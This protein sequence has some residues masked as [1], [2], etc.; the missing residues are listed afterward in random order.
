MKTNDWPSRFDLLGQS[1]AKRITLA[2][3]LLALF[4]LSCPRVGNGIRPQKT[5][6]RTGNRRFMSSNLPIHAVHLPALSTFET[7]P[8]QAQTFIIDGVS[9]EN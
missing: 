7:G 4:V 3:P 8:A 5:P 6:I 9:L 1:E 2:A